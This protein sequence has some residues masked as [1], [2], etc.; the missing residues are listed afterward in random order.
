V[1]EII[2]IIVPVLPFDTPVKVAL[3][4]GR[5]NNAFGVVEEAGGTYRLHELNTLELAAKKQGGG[6]TL[7]SLV[8]HDLKATRNPIGQVRSSDE[9]DVYLLESLNADVAIRGF[10]RGKTGDVASI[11]G[12]ANPQGYLPTLIRHSWYQCVVNKCPDKTR[13][14]SAGTCAYLH[15]LTKRP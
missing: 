15:A 14:A 4:Q 3:T 13:Y 1:R 6:A 2:S 9:N 5:A 7:G 8:G 10:L 11:I 12:F